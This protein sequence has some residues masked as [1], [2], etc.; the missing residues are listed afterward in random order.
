MHDSLDA[1]LVCGLKNVVTGGEM[2]RVR[3]IGARLHTQCVGQIGRSNIDGVEAR[4]GADGV[5]VRKTLLRLDHGHDDDLVIRVGRVVSA[6]V[7]HGAH[8]S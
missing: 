5:K 8:G 1:V 3:V 7:L 6:G 4:R 2:S